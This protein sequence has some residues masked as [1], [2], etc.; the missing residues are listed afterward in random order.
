MFLMDVIVS[1]SHHC[2]IVGILP[3]YL[4][5]VCIEDFSIC[6]EYGCGS[7]AVAGRCRKPARG[8]LYSMHA[9]TAACHDANRFSG[10][11]ISSVW[12]SRNHNR[13]SAP[14]PD[15]E[16]PCNPCIGDVMCSW[17]VSSGSTKQAIAPPPSLTQSTCPTL[18]IGGF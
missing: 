8:H 13:D 9:G 7:D 5:C 4:M 10:T 6:K 11:G 14:H 12:A 17:R 3:D 16:T 1:V 15:P 2:L 18:M